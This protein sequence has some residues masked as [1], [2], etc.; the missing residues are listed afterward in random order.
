MGD[1]Q[2]RASFNRHL[3][4]PWAELGNLGHDNNRTIISHGRG[5]LRLR[6]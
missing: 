4:H 1:S 5:I 2:Q 6:C 3:L